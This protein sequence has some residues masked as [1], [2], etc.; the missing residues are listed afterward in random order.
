VDLWTCR[1]GQLLRRLQL[2][3]GT[4][5]SS[6]FAGDTQVPV[7]DPGRGRI[8]TGRLWSYARDDRP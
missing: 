5:L 1:R 3:L 7:P 8:R 4:L 6:S 2:P